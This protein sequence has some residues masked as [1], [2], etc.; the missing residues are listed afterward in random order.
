VFGL[1]QLSAPCKRLR[2]LGTYVKRSVGDRQAC[3][4][5]PYCNWHLKPC[6]LTEQVSFVTWPAI[7]GQSNQ[8]K[9]YLILQQLTCWI[10]T[11]DTKRYIQT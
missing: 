9:V 5:R 2:C 8:I 4:C 7:R 10:K 1:E 11:N 6:Y 3:K